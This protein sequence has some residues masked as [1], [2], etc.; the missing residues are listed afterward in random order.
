M[1][2][3]VVGGGGREHALCWKIAQSPLVTRVHCAPGN[4]GIQELAQ[5]W[6]VQAEDVAGIVA[7][8]KEIR[9]GLV[10]VGPEAPLCAGLVDAL[11]VAGIKA[12]GPTQK[13]AAI[14]GDKA[15]AREMCRR[16]RILGPQFWIFEDLRVALSFLDNREPGPVVV[17]AAGLAAGKG[18]VV[19]KNGD[20][21]RVAVRACLEHN[22]FGEAGK[23]IVIEECLEGPEVSMIVLTDSRTIVPLDPCQDHKRV[24]DGDQGPNTGGMGAFSPVPSVRGRILAQIENQIL[25]P[26]VHAMN[27]EGRPFSGFLYAG[28]MLTP[29]GPRVLEFNCRLGDPET[30]PLLMRMTSDLVPLLLATVDGTLEKCE[31]PSWDAGTAVCVMATSAGYPGEFGKG[32]PIHGLDQI[33]RSPQ[34]MVFHSGTVR[35]AT[36]TVTSGGRVL[37]TCALGKDAREARERAYAAMGKIEF[38]GMHY[39]KDIAGR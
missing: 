14:E 4:A 26:A 37:A 24:F 38:A 29:L 17:K 32:V 39:R 11:T 28:L 18:V 31:A 16:H 3:L 13:A 35:R 2:V 6:P 25:L 22:R 36:E 7:L 12:F 30:Q 1:N 27:R 20:E 19:C 34:L 23:R 8:A 21:A 15:F 33:E 5:I 10:V 9:A